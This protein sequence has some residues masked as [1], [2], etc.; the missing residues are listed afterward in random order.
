MKTST[1]NTANNS[2]FQVI[3]ILKQIHINK[4]TLLFM[5]FVL[6]V[7]FVE[8]RNTNC[9]HLIAADQTIIDASKMDVQPGDTVCIEASVKRMLLIS[10]FHGTADNYI[11]FKNCGGE[12]IVKNNDLTYGI[13]IDNCSY[14]RFT[15]AGV[16]GTN[17]GVRILETMPGGSMGIKIGNKS[18]NYEIDH[19]E[20]AN[21]GFAG[22]M[23][24]TDPKSD[25]SSNRDSFTQY[26]SIFHDNYIHNVGGVGM[27]IGHSFYTGVTTTINGQDILLYPSVLKGV[28]VYNNVV[29]S[30]GWDGIQVGSATDDCEIYSNSVTYYGLKKISSQHSGFQVNPGT[31][32]KLYNN[33]VANGTGNGMTIFGMGNIDVY[34][35]III[36]AG[37]DYFP[38]EQ[39][40]IHGIFVD[41][42]VTIPGSSFN[43]FNNTIVNPK[44]DGI[45]FTSVISKNNKFYNNIILNPGS[46]STYSV[47]SNQ[48]SY[49]NI[50]VK[51][52]VDA[53]ISN[54]FLDNNSNRIQFQDYQK[55]NFKLM[56][57]SPAIEAGLDLSIYGVEYDFEHNARPIGRHY[58]IGAYQSEYTAQTKLE[59]KPVANFDVFPNPSKGKFEISR[60]ETSN[61]NV[62]IHNILGKVVRSIKDITDKQF[63]F[64]ITDLAVNGKYFVT[65]SD[66]NGSSTRTIIIQ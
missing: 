11:V 9:K 53:N 6:S 28:R 10:N 27:Y 1:H 38:N 8:A 54:N 24:K 21:V 7:S 56:S 52:G 5:I 62:T 57:S 46:L 15:G 60:E 31:T 20:I 34:N 23:A 66:Q 59:S 25:L 22:I 17:Y 36:N 30:V 63:E 47:Y 19:I 48:T 41:D 55:S 61:V 58:D 42:R 45:R 4:F 13:C 35:N 37:Y 26:Q 40:N 51:S 65:V 49:I 33:Y 50:G 32:G 18:T 39:K 64:D 12:V 3:A 44:A 29:D 16:D 2:L 14:F 43:F